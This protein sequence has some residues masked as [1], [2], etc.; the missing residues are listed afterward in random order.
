MWNLI[1]KKKTTKKSIY[2][3]ILLQL[4]KSR[5]ERRN[6]ASFSIPWTTHFNDLTE[7]NIK[8]MLYWEKQLFQEYLDDSVNGKEKLSLKILLIFSKEKETR[9]RISSF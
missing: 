2:V 4:I 1:Q 8:S 3:Q 6:Q 7:E 5:E 9:F